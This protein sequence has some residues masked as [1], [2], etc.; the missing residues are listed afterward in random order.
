MHLTPSLLLGA[1]SAGVF[2]MAETAEDPK[3]YWFDPDPRAILPL[4]GVHV[5][6]RL[7]RTARQAPY[8]ITVDTAFERVLIQCGPQRPDGKATWMNREIF[9]ALLGLYQL[10]YAHS[11]EAWRDGELVGGLYGIALGAAFCAESM[12]STATDAS[13]LC[14]LHLVARLRAGG[15]TLLDAQIINDHTRQFGVIEIGR[16]EY[17]RRLEAALGVSCKF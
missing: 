9:A 16:D 12:F 13:K 6:R 10:G 1:Y 8:A 3:L 14:L 4:D 11:V 5:P 15:F 7:A 17:H 2:P